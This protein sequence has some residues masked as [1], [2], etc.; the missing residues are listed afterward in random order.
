MSIRDEMRD[1]IKKSTHISFDTK[2]TK[3]D[4]ANRFCDFL[5]D[6]NIQLKRV[7]NIRTKDLKAYVN[8]QLKNGKSKRSIQNE[9]ATIRGV[10]RDCG[11]AHFADKPE[12]SNSSLGISRASRKGTN[13]AMTKEVFETSQRE[14]LNVSQSYS[15]LHFN[16]VTA[17]H[18]SLMYN[19]GLRSK[20]V[21]MSGQSLKE[22]E[23][24]L[25]NGDRITIIHGTKGGK[26]RD[27]NI[28]D[29]ESALS[30]IKEAQNYINEKGHLSPYYRGRTL[31][32][33]LDHF[34]YM[35]KK[36]LK[37]KGFTA[38]S[39]RYAFAQSQVDAYKNEGYSASEAYSMASLDL[40]HGS[41]RGR[42]IKHVYD[43]REAA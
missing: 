19:L 13:Q 42:Y 8:E 24:Q 33:E 1:Y 40:G 4:Q 5:H 27:V 35:M 15:S 21:V 36:T 7:E 12:N 10:L 23:R 20:E 26:I 6:K 30:A 9:I 28:F 41:E 14:L 31:K 43:Q 37:E 32:S 34:H 29:K 2:K 39:A 18:L 22:W 17:A 38:H 3:Y 11:K 25:N 16:R